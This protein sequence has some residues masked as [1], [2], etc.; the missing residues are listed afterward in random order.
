MT[1]RPSTQTLEFS[2][3]DAQFAA[4]KR[5]ERFVGESVRPILTRTSDA[6]ALDAT[7]Q[8]IVVRVHAWIR[9]LN[10]LNHPGDFQAI[11][12]AS[13]ALFEIAVDLT[14]LKFD[15][16]SPCEK[17]IAW[18]ESAKLAS[19]DRLK[20]FCDAHPGEVPVGSESMLTFLAQRDRIVGLRRQHWRNDRH[21]NRWTGRNL[22]DDAT[23]ADRAQP[24]GLAEYYA[25]RYSQVCWSVHGSGL[26]SVRTITT[27]RFPG[28]SALGLADAAQFSLVACER[29]LQ[30]VERWDDISKSRFEYFA[31]E[32]RDVRASVWLSYGAPR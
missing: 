21:P 27:D 4:C 17:L 26:T 5:I 9:S 6:S 13:R 18:E 2:L 10:K 1:E 8:G 30:L 24:C 29:A 15:Q 19:V 22:E 25:T 7:V 14:L 32:L 16:S 11:L 20:R 23:V 3:A 31:N 12:S 28:L